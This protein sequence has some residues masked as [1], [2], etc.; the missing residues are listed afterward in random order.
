MERMLA[1]EFAAVEL[2]AAQSRP[3]FALLMG[4]LA[5]EFSGAGEEGGRS[6]V[7]FLVVRHLSV[8]VA[9]PPPQSLPPVK[10]GTV[11][12]KGG[13]MIQSTA[14]FLGQGKA[15]SSL[16]M[17]VCLHWLSLLLWARGTVVGAQSG[18]AP[19]VVGRHPHSPLLRCPWCNCA[20]GI[21]CVL[22]N[23]AIDWGENGM[24]L[25]HGGLSRC[26]FSPPLNP[27]QRGGGDYGPQRGE[28]TMAPK[29]GEVARGWTANDPGIG[30]PS[31]PPT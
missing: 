29:G 7:G 30:T 1:T 5:T 13:R 28:V 3:E 14:C 19:A 8:F 27:P 18:K 12:P 2:P 11:A 25:D 16:L 6:A 26:G 15:H 20:R 24:V 21:I 23:G 31:F 10:A 4:H 9:I 17:V 22:E